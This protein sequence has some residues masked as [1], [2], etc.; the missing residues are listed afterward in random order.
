MNIE[1]KPQIIF[2]ALATGISFG[3]W[4]NNFYAG[5]FMFGALLTFALIFDFTTKR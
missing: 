3:N 5:L 1:E 2:V 4:T